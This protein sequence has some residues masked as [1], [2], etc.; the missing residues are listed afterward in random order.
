[1][2]ARELSPVVFLEHCTALNLF[3][4]IGEHNSQP[5]DVIER[6]NRRSRR[7]K[8]AF[9]TQIEED[10]GSARDGEFRSGLCEKELAPTSKWARA[11][12]PAN[13][14]LFYCA[15]FVPEWSVFSSSDIG[16][17]MNDPW[18]WVVVICKAE[19]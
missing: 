6:I 12:E 15:R 19:N 13:P 3:P 11:P 7:G 16:K 1:M 2:T 10:P 9:R 5:P 8:S 4:H 17:V 14:D 18:W